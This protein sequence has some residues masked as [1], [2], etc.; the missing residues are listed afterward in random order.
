MTDTHGQPMGP[1]TWTAPCS[2]LTLGQAAWRPHWYHAQCLRAGLAS[3]CC[4]V[5]S[6][7]QQPYVT[8]SWWWHL[9]V[10]WCP[11]QQCGQL[12]AGAPGLADEWVQPRTRQHGVKVLLVTR[13]HLQ[14]NIAQ[15][16][17]SGTFFR[18]A[19]CK[20]AGQEV[21]EQDKRGALPPTPW[22]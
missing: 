1:C 19:R 9:G 22:L 12:G 13:Q 11:G 5:Q 2:A 20:V 8:R 4:S 15:Q 18:T 16:L 3:S 10:S 17:R 21:S 6:G 14:D 7:V